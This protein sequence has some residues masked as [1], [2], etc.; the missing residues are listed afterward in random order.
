VGIE[1]RGQLSA[2]WRRGFVVLRGD[3]TGGTEGLDS[4]RLRGRLTIVSQNLARQTLLAHLEGGAVQRP[5]PGAEF[6]LWMEQRGPR[7]FGAHQFTGNRMAWL[8]IEDRIL[9]AD[10]VWGLVGVGLAPFF[11]YG[12]AWYAD[13]AARW[14][15]DAGVALRL[16][17]TRSVRGDAAEFAVGYRFG[18]GK[19]WAIALRQAVVF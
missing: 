11:D 2:V 6:D 16:G 18:E 5:K 3:A 17:P 1:A 14:G 13:E 19:G 4:T 15:G 10:D 9:V 7:L 12:G 8:V